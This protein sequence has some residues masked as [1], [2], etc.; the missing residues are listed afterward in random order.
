MWGLIAI[1]VT[2]A[3]GMAIMINNDDDDPVTADDDMV[4]DDQDETAGFTRVSD[5]ELL[6]TG[7]DDTLMAEDIE[8]PDL[9]EEVNSG[10]GDDTID[11]WSGDDTSGEEEYRTGLSIDTGAGNDAVEVVGESLDITLGDGDDTLDAALLETT[12]DGGAGDDYLDVSDDF[13][14]ED[15]EDPDREE[16]AQ[17]IALTVDGGEGDDTIDASGVDDAVLNGGAG[18]DLIITGGGESPG[19]TGYNVIANGGE[20]DDVIQYLV[21]TPVGPVGLEDYNG[22]S[23]GEG[24]DRFELTINEGADELYDETYES[25]ISGETLTYLNNSAVFEDENTLRIST[26]SI[27]DFEPGVDTLSLDA[28]PLNEGY[29]LSELTLEENEEGTS[30]DLILT[31]ERADDITRQVVVTLGSGGVTIDDIELV[32]DTD[33]DAGDDPN[34]DPGDGDQPG[35]IIVDED[36]NLTG[37]DGD[38]TVND[39]G[40]D[41]DVTDTNPVTADLG[42]GDDVA[43]DGDNPDWMPEE[44]SGGDGNDQLASET[45]GVVL[46]GDA[47]DDVLSGVG[48]SQLFGGEGEDTLTMDLAYGLNDTAGVAEGGDGNDQ[49]NILTEIV[50]D[51]LPDFS[52]VLAT[53]GDGSDVFNVVIQ[54]PTTDDFD[55]EDL[56]LPDLVESPSGVVIA[57]FNPEEDTLSIELDDGTVAPFDVVEIR[58]DAVTNSTIVDLFF[59]GSETFPRIV[60]S[61][62][63][64]DAPDISVE[65]VI[66]VE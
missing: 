64:V 16:A 54:T 61:I 2:G 57:D 11:L 1:W 52:S 48:A 7:L 27:T 55:P 36:G 14:G 12:V 9:L 10:D 35:E 50:K 33:G 18:N 19:G 30:T 37:T 60:T 31:Y 65:D 34:D 46:N 8:D 6:G 26:I 62:R 66:I 49:L 3:I 56:P 23:G 51:P 4:D 15:P 38:D 43:I 29:E 53:G 41:G 40:E 20:G 44:I 42:A 25:A 32:E 47:G 22:A 17:V 59:E 21:T 63:L 28:A 5:T 13:P 39:T 45:F 58:N 24:A